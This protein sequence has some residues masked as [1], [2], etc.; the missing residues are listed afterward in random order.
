MNVKKI[1]LVV[2]GVVTS[3]VWLVGILLGLVGKLLWIGIKV[4]WGLV[5]DST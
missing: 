4:G 5:N 3:P 2:F 1:L